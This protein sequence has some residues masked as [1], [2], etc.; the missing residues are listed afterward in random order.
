MSTRHS[1]ARAIVF[2]GVA[3]VTSATG[4][5]GCH[6]EPYTGCYPGSCPILETVAHV[7]QLDFSKAFDVDDAT[8]DNLAKAA[9]ASMRLHDLDNYLSSSNYVACER[10]L[11]DLTALGV[12]SERYRPCTQLHDKIQEALHRIG[13]GAEIKV[14][15]GSGACG[16]DVKR[17]ARCLAKCERR[18]VMMLNEFQCSGPMFCSAACP[19][20]CAPDARAADFPVG[21]CKGSCSGA[22]TGDQWCV[23]ELEG[24][25]DSI[26]CQVACE[27]D[28]WTGRY[29]APSTFWVESDGPY[30]TKA[31]EALSTT[32]SK[33]LSIVRSIAAANERFILLAARAKRAMKHAGASLSNMQGEM[34]WRFR[35]CRV[36]SV[37]R[38]LAE[39]GYSQNPSES[40]EEVWRAVPVDESLF[41]PARSRAPVTVPAP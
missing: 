22:C 9:E 39:W 10:V 29:C 11:E 2:A 26:E 38:R 25:D 27:A 13:P 35:S 1:C 15:R 7:Q 19:G 24:P 32:L 30:D 21:E 31:A 14:S 18:P 40:A 34:S 41:T 28:A 6:Q 5:A 12:S 3:V 17:A 23:G 33:N 4:V 37:Y 16:V 20:D 8:G 36:D